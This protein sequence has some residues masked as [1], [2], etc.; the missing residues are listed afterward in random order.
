[1]LGFAPDERLGRVAEEAIFA[2]D[3]AAVALRFAQVNDG[4]VEDLR[5]E[6]CMNHKDGHPLW[7]LAYR[8]RC[9]A[10]DATRRPLYTIVQ[11]INIDRQKQAEAALAESESR[12]NFAL[13]SAGQGVWDHDIRSDGMAP[14]GGMWR[15]MR[16]IPEDEPIDPSEEKWLARLHPDDVAHVR[17]VV[18]AAAGS[19]RRWLRHHGISRAPSRRPLRPGC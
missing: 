15:R 5:I 9:C 17:L 8:P 14:L 3:R 6:C 2:D 7:V 16:C 4:E 18:R 12:W 11:I 19:R 1:M 13:E 10:S